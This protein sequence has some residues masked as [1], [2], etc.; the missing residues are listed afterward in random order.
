M[1]LYQHHLQNQDL[2]QEN[3]RRLYLSPGLNSDKDGVVVK[4]GIGMR[5]C[6]LA[7]DSPFLLLAFEDRLKDHFD[8]VETFENGLLALEA[9]K[10]QSIDYY[11]AIVLDIQMPIM[12]GIEACIQIKKFFSETHEQI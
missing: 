8:A 2:E 11:Q 1:P 12:N 5:R 10:A 9:V 3:E 4:N 6:L 7:N